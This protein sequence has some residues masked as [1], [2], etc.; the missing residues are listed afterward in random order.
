MIFIVSD[1]VLCHSRLEYF[2]HS[3]LT[4][5]FCPYVTELLQLPVPGYG[6]VYRHISE[7]LTYRAVGSS[8]H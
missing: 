7:M 8:G 3:I 1:T 5:T 4:I 2:S 6:T